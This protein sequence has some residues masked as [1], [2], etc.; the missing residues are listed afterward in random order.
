M[1]MFSKPEKETAQRKATPKTNQA[2]KGAVQTKIKIGSP[3]DKYEQ[4]ADA[5]ADKVISMPAPKASG[6]GIQRKCSACEQE[7]AQTKPLASLITPLVQRMSPE[8]EDL[9]TGAQAK[10]ETPDQ[11]DSTNES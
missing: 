3:N 4:E 2:R 10:V 9:S 7:E 6:E 8:E 11:A 1:P 5:M